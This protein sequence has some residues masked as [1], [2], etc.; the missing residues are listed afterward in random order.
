MNPTAVRHRR[1]LLA[2]LLPVALLL[3]A[4]SCDDG[5]PP[6]ALDE[7]DPAEREY[8]TRFVVLERARAVSFADR[9]L[10]E[11]LLDS[12]AA[13]W[14]DS[15]LVDAQAALPD[16]PQ[17]MAALHALLEAV[18]EAEKDSLLE[19]P[20]PDRLSAPLPPVRLDVE[21]DDGSAT[22]G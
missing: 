21:P 3:G 4:A 16:D 7:L 10:G 20:R 9:T 1:R 18:L 8:L 15:S 2:A 6:V 11:A 14:G 5:A 12:L 17:R 22:D 19:A 13:D